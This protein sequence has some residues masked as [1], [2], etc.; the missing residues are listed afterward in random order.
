MCIYANK[1]CIVCA[2]IAGRVNKCEDFDKITS[3]PANKLMRMEALSSKWSNMHT[4]EDMSKFAT[5]FRCVLCPKCKDKPSKQVAVEAVTKAIESHT[6]N[7][8]GRFE[9]QDMQ[10]TTIRQW[11]KTACSQ[12]DIES[13]TETE[14]DTDN[15]TNAD[16]TDNEDE[17]MDPLKKVDSLVNV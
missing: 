7:L 8:V 14:N 17:N 11:F 15:D 10:G 6:H 12:T 13:A 3:N 16:T 2:N 9:L 5:K 4:S 1:V